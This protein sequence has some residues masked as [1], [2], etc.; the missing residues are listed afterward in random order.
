MPFDVTLRALTDLTPKVNGKHPFERNYRKA[1]A[2]LWEYS[3]TSQYFI[4]FWTY[5]WRQAPWMMG[6][7]YIADSLGLFSSPAHDK[8]SGIGSNTPVTNIL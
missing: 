7:L 2:F 5:F 6:T 1:F 4:G 3:Y 8:Y